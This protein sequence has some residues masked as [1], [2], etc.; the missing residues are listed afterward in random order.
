MRHRL[1]SSSAHF[2]VR[3]RGIKLQNTRQLLFLSNSVRNM[4]SLSSATSV[5]RFLDQNGAIRCGQQVPN[6]N[7]AQL[8]EQN[9]PLGSLILTGETA[10]IKKILIPVVPSQILC[11]GLNYRKHAQETNMPEPSHPI[12]FTKS[13]NALQHP[14]DPIVI[15]RIASDPK[16]VDYECELAVVL[17]E[18]CKNVS[19]SDALKYVGGYTCANDI[20]ARRWQGKKGGNQWCR[21][22]SF[23]T[24]CPLGPVLVTPQVISDPQK[25]EIATYLNGKV[26]QKSSTSD[27]IFSVAEL[28]SQ[29][30]QDMTLPKGT[31]ILTG[32]PEV[33]INYTNL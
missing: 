12:L 29:L 10:M 19:V 25:L 9:D 15:P 6:T 8:V 30:S 32:T 31:I 20:S 16:E 28:I 22:K 27:M 23:D 1:V 26:M 18:T 14:N 5:V 3:Y 21:A 11:I 2:F 7:T 4:S 24:F 13:L 33:C 17:K